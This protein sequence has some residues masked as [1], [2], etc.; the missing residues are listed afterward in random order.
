MYFY[1]DEDY[2][3][4][5]SEQIIEEL[6]TKP[7]KSFDRNSFEFRV[8]ESIVKIHRKPKEDNIFSNWVDRN[9]EHLYNLYEMS[10]V[11]ISMEDFFNFV[12]DHSQK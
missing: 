1:S 5:D 12:F 11:K 8:A 4:E 9:F 3:D 7:K 2:S 6:P 10:Q